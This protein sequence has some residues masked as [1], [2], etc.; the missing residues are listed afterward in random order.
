MKRYFTQNAVFAGLFRMVETLFGIEIEE[1]RA[2]VWHPDVKYFEVKR[3]G[4]L[5]AA[6]YADLYRSERAHV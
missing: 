2:S 6:F 1:K 3:E 4:K 5:I